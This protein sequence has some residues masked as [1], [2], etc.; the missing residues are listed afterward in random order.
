MKRTK[1]NKI[2]FPR[3]NAP[4]WTEIDKELAIAL[5]RV[6]NTTYMSATSGAKAAAKLGDWLYTFFSDKF[7]VKDEQKPTPHTNRRE[8]S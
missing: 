3:P 2:N 8:P 6:F 1:K 4:E 5:P 7:G